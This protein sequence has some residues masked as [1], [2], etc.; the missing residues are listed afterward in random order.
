MT[1]PPGLA[2]LLGHGYLQR[3]AGRVHS[4]QSI[5]R[6]EAETTPTLVVQSQPRVGEHHLWQ[7]RQRAQ[8][9]LEP[10]RDHC[11]ARCGTN[12]GC[13]LYLHTEQT[14]SSSSSLQPP[15]LPLSHLDLRMWLL[16]RDIFHGP[17]SNDLSV[18]LLLRLAILGPA[19]IRALGIVC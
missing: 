10:A 13:I 3:V 5:Q 17:A 4:P 8:L 15:S 7:S 6:E 9:P 2:P 1:N 11:L 16:R 19:I 14:S 18:A 12:D